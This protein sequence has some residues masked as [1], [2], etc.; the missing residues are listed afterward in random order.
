MRAGRVIDGVS[1][2]LPA[3]RR[4][5]DSVGVTGSIEMDVQV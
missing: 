3:S 5:E 4:L 2:V 1:T